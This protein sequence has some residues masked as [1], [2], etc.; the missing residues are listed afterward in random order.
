MRSAGTL[1]NRDPKIKS[2]ARLRLR[3]LVQ[4]AL[5]P[6]IAGML[7]EKQAP[8]EGAFL[9]S[10]F[11]PSNRLCSVSG[12]PNPAVKNLN[13]LKTGMSFVSCAPQ[14]GRQLGQA[15]ITRQMRKTLIVPDDMGSVYIY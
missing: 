10:G 15:G 5:H 12:Y 13:L 3:K 8:D 4:I 14:Q 6:L 9:V 1:K 11:F 7:L 2:A